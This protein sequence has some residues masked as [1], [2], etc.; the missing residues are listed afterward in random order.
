ML[1]LLVSYRDVCH[2]KRSIRSIVLFHFPPSP[3]SLLFPAIISI[4]V[5]K[6][7]TISRLGEIFFLILKWRV[8]RLHFSGEGKFRTSWAGGGGRGGEGGGDKCETNR[9]FRAG[10]VNAI[11]PNTRRN[12]KKDGGEK[13]WRRKFETFRVNFY[14][15]ER[16]RYIH[17]HTPPPPSSP[18]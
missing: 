3:F 7:P 18:W 6:I 14:R 5:A 15:L 8:R 1:L 12:G 17:T 9:K 4:I 11:L 16:D 10:R 13:A 2:S